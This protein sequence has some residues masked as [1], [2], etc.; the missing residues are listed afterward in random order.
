[1]PSREVTRPLVIDVPVSIMS[2]L[3]ICGRWPGSR[4]G[5]PGRVGQ[6]RPPA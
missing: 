1:V 5:A 6:A 4:R 3:G 2:I